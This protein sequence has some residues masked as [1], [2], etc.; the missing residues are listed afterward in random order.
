[1]DLPPGVKAA[2]REE[3]SQRAQVASI[4]QTQEH[5]DWLNT[6][7]LQLHDGSAGQADIESARKSGRL[8]D[9]DE[10]SRLE[11]IVKQREKDGA[12]MALFSTMMADPHFGFNQYD[13]SQR[14]AVEAGVKAMGGTA[15][16]AFNVWQK[17]G[18]LAKSGSVAL[19]GG[20]VSTNPMTVQA[21]ANIAGN[22][23]R[24]NPNAFAGVDGESDIER[25]SV[26]FNHYIYDLGMSPKEAAGKVAQEN[27]PKFKEK[28]KF[29]EPERQESL[30]TLRQQGV[31]AEQFLGGKFAND[32]MRGA[33]NEAFHELIVDQL[34]KGSPNL[35]TA[36]TQAAHQL[37]KVWGVN[38]RG[39]VVPY[40]PEKGYPDIRGSWDYVYADA[41]ATVKQ[42]T[43]RDPVQFNL[44]PIPGITDQDFRAGKPPRYRIV[45]SH[46]VNGQTVIDTVPGEFAA[47]VASAKKGQSESDRRRFGQERRHAIE[48]Q[49][50]RESENPNN[51]AALGF[52]E[53]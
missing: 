52:P 48:Q 6:F 39:V 51:I 18:I 7:E 26:A 24:R 31:N 30:K 46:T 16:E 29:T 44:V 41:K 19:R 4:I 38:S 8:T 45:Y 47:D 23:I 40:P 32:N 34:A 28:V 33:A 3:L 50:Q 9:Y 11:D 53:R 2:A 49:R 22:M 37:Q 1:M 17:T 15:E 42:V 43:G 14:K 13:D 12:D 21:A 25:A 27:D 36:M 20:L 10:V 35:G 5:N